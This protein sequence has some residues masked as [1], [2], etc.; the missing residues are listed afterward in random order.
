MINVTIHYTFKESIKRIFT[1]IFFR[2]VEWNFSTKDQKT[3]KHLN[4][5][6]LQCGGWKDKNE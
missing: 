3:E 6:F 4:K 5:L 2:R 1:L